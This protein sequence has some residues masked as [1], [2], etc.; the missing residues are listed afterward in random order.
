MRALMIHGGVSQ[1]GIGSDLAV[2]LVSA[3]ARSVI[4]ARMYPRLAR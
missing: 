1:T 3:A 2:L 4:G